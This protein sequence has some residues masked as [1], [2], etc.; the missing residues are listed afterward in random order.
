MRN[1]NEAEA[2]KQSM[3]DKAETPVAAEGTAAPAGEGGRKTDTLVELYDPDTHIYNALGVM[4]LLPRRVVFIV[5]E[6]ASAVYRKYKDAYRR[7]WE[8]RG[9]VPEKVEFVETHTSDMMELAAVL[10]AFAG[11]DAVLDIEGGTPELYLAAGYVYSRAPGGFSCIR[12]DF[13]DRKLTSYSKTGDGSET[14]VRMFTDE[15][16]ARVSLSVDECIRIY[17]GVVERSTVTE[18]LARG[19][20]MEEISR[21]TALV[22][23]AMV[24]RSRRTWN[25]LVPDRLH[26]KGE[27]SLD[28]YVNGNEAK[29]RAVSN[30]VADLVSSGALK[31]R[32]G[33]PSRRWYRCR[34]HAVAACLKSAGALLELYMNSVACNVSSDGRA[35]S[36]VSLSFDGEEGSS[37]NEIDCIFM[38]GAI[39][40]FI[41]CKNGRVGSEELY[42]FA[43]VTTQF[44]GNEKIAVLV[45]PSLDGRDE[46][47]PP[48]RI[49]SVRERAE[50]YGIRII[51]DIYDISARA[52]AA[53][54]SRLVT[55]K[56]KI[57][58]GGIK[59]DK[60][61]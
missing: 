33:D 19:M 7:L 51:T 44:G 54:L 10:E 29:I 56:D 17:G 31:P 26:M 57:S 1:H 58:G 2:D 12:L 3:A 38:L 37:D 5:P 23:S 36:G 18:L 32:G 47:I 40:V 6:H 34:S 55:K 24:R 49:K 53:E 50:L 27:H 28:I 46:T 30:L 22:W 41:S 4:L 45:A 11:D 61:T 39:P 20:T 13:A 48:S 16:T 21:D 25:D 9:C 8:S 52:A 35:V 15:E 43:A 59:P 42:K 60:K 14:V